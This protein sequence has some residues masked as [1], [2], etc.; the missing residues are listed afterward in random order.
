MNFLDYRIKLK[1][2]LPETC[3]RKSNRLVIRMPN[4]LGDIVMAIPVVKAILHGRAD[5]HLTILCKPQYAEWLKSLKLADKVYCL[6]Q[7]HG[8]QYYFQFLKLKKEY[9]DAQFNFTNSLRGDIEA[10]I[11]GA[12]K[13]FG[14]QRRG[15]RPLLNRVYNRLSPS[16]KHQT[17]V[18]GDMLKHFGFRAN[19]TFPLS[20]SSWVSL[21]NLRLA[22]APGEF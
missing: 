21:K 7:D 5:M 17:N 13:R 9:P 15:Q 2:F 16:V 19:L 18:W 8:V 6:E 14:L 1:P 20:V 11:I 4:W 3:L 10:F 22:E 12:P